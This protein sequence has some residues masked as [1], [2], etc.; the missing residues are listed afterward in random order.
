MKQNSNQ[1][2]VEW[3]PDLVQVPGASCLQPRNTPRN[4]E[5]SEGAFASILRNLSHFV[6]IET[7]RVVFSSLGRFLLRILYLEHRPVSPT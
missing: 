1:T 7:A 2:R 4:T 3:H 5:G 6:V